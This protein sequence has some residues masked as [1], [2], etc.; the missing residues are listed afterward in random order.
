MLAALR[1][2]L[3]ELVGSKKVMVAA[4]SG[5]A[6]VLLYVLGPRLGLDAAAANECATRLMAIAGAYLVGQ[7]VADHGATAAEVHAEGGK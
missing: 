3:V 1:G 2:V 4:T 7:G 5:L 6:T